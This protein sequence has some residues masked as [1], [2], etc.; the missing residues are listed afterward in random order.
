VIAVTLSLDDVVY[1]SLQNV[2]SRSFFMDL[3]ERAQHAVVTFFRP[4]RHTTPSLDIRIARPDRRRSARV[5]VEAQL[6]IETDDGR[7]YDGFCRDLSG[8]GTAA[9]INGDL[10]T[11]ERIHLVFHD[12]HGARPAV[13][14]A[15]V[16]QCYG[17]RYGLEFAGKSQQEVADFVIAACK[18]CY[19]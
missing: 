15:I 14:Q 11:G 19:A 8:E 5:E 7:R 3:L 16:R 18:S 4:V 9:L 12:I 6:T 1:D 2:R 13:I 10:Q 17:R